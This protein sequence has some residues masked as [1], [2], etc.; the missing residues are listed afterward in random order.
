MPS[1][2]R[3]MRFISVCACLSLTSCSTFYMVEGCQIVEHRFLW[4]EVAAPEN[5][6]ICDEVEVRYQPTE[7]PNASP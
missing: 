5:V 6:E 2:A 4:W 7:A 3:W 1:F